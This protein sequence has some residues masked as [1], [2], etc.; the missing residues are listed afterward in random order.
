[1]TLRSCVFLSGLK[2]LFVSCLL[3]LKKRPVSQVFFVNH[4]TDGTL[5]TS[6]SY[7]CTLLAFQS[8]KSPHQQDY[9]PLT[10]KIVW[11]TNFK[12]IKAQID[13]LSWII[14]GNIFLLR[15]FQLINVLFYYNQRLSTFFL[16]FSL[17]ATFV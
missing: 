17:E 2:Q 6:Y 4:S 7:S 11:F 8:L 13:K 12:L 1:M 16:L 15:N 5:D 9:Y 14:R 10:C 3:I